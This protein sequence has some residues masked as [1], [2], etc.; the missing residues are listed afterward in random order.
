MTQFEKLDR[1]LVWD[2][3]NQVITD[4]IRRYMIRI[5][6]I[7]EKVQASEYFFSK[8]GDQERQNENLLI[9]E[10]E[11]AVLSGRILEQYGN[12]GRGD[13]C[14][15]AG[16]SNSGK[17]IHVICGRRGEQLVVVTVYIPGPPKF[18]TPY[19]RR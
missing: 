3:D 9:A 4:R 10:V 6:W 14:L 1:I 13:C 15:V 5:E 18:R 16:F 17:P 7:K 12:T 19:E 2:V 8:H 11:E